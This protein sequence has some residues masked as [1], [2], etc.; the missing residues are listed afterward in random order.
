MKPV[1]AVAVALGATARAEKVSTCVPVTTLVAPAVT[2]TRTVMTV[3][4]VTSSGVGDGVLRTYV[5]GASVVDDG[6]VV[7]GTTEMTG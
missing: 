2:V 3:V 5:T 4:R 1:V 6:D 7:V